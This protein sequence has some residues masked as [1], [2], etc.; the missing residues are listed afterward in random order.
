MSPKGRELRG[1]RRLSILTNTRMRLEIFIYY[2]KCNSPLSARQLFM[3]RVSKA[4]VSM[5][6]CSSK[7][8]IFSNLTWSRQEV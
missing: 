3:C 6:R 2:I 4:I 5:A 8:C 1:S 7:D